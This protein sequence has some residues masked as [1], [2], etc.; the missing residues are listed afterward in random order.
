MGTG[1]EKV[2]GV[3]VGGMLGIWGFDVYSFEVPWVMMIPR[4]IGFLGKNR[5][6][7]GFS[8]VDQ[9]KLGGLWKAKK[10]L[11]FYLGYQKKIWT[12]IG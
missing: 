11:G 5:G 4:N 8:S 1:R 10:K 12:C 6:K 2:V 7:N 9:W 3:C